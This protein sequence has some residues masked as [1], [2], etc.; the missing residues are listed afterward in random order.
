MEPEIELNVPAV[1]ADSTILD[2]H[3][4]KKTSHVSSHI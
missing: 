4:R 2:W 1:Q 3:W